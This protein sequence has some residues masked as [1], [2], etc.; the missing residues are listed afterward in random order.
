M[1]SGDATTK[2]SGAERLKV[3][4]ELAV[5][6][7]G[8]PPASSE[9]LW[10]VRVGDDTAR[11]ENIPFF[12]RGASLGDVVRFGVNDDGERIVEDVVG[13]SDNCTIRVIPAEDGHLVEQRQAVLDAFTP[14]GVTGEGIAQFGMVA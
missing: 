11:L 5:D 6:D 10:A 12:V 7:D 1:T 8:W 4:F 14:F 13:Y 3:V 2:E 9:R